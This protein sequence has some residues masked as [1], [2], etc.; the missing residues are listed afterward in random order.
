MYSKLVRFKEEEGHVNPPFTHP[1]LGSW[2]AELRRQKKSLKKRGLEHEQK[3]APKM[4]VVMPALTSTAAETAKEEEPADP[5]AGGDAH[6]TPEA[7]QTTGSSNNDHV[8]DPTSGDLTA[9]SDLLMTEALALAAAKAAS[10]DLV[11]AG[12]A[13]KTEEELQTT[14][15]PDNAHLP[16]SASGDPVIAAVVA[17]DVTIASELGSVKGDEGKPGATPATTAAGEPKK[18][19]G[20]HPATFLTRFRVRLL[21]HIQFDWSG[22]NRRRTWDQRLGE[23][24]KFH[25]RHA[26]WPGAKDGAL[27]NW[28]KKQKQRYAKKEAHF[29]A[30]LYPQVCLRFSG[31]PDCSRAFD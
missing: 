29:M 14:E 11:A 26:K 4:A 13:H 17:A 5:S 21:N 9:A 16:D 1:E 24:K 31:R 18:V 6:N 19:V 23:L 28:L 8:A 7:L 10:G 25:E 2:V 27:G 15:P 20:P 3:E 12:D 30:N 22:V